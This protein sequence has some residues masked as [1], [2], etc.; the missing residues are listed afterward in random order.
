[1]YFKYTGSGFLQDIG[2]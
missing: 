1:M 2:V